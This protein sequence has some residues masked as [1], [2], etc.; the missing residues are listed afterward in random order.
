MNKIKKLKTKCGRRI[1]K[2]MAEEYVYGTC[3]NKQNYINYVQNE[4]YEMACQEKLQFE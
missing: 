1:C 2:P 4:C 3:R